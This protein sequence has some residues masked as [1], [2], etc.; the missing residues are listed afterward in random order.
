MDEKKE[1]LSSPLKVKML[2]RFSVSYNDNIIAG[3][4]NYSES[5]FVY[6]LQMLI[7]AG[8][9]GVA[10]SSLE[11]VLFES[12]YINNIRH[13]TQSVIYN[14]KTKLKQCG[15]PDCNYIEHKDGVFYWTDKIPGGRRP[16][17]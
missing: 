13:A 15:L 5:Q 3:G 2:G 1:I 11:E 14:A 7:H 4:S 8:E 6:L 16:F 10:R 17:F 12:R 9:K